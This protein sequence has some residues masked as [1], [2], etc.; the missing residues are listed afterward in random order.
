[1]I[2]DTLACT[3][4]R[5]LLVNYRIEPDAVAPLLPAGFRPQLVGGFAVGGVCFIRLAGI[6][7]SRFPQVLGITTEN[8]AHR[9][10]VEWGDER[11]ARVGVYVPRRDTDSHIASVAGGRVFPGRYH[12]AR[13]DVDES[14]DA[15]AIDVRSR[16]GVVNLSVAGTES[17]GLDS[18]LFASLDDATTF[19]RRGALGFSPAADVGCLDAVRL[20]SVSWDAR[21]VQLR[22]MQS[23]LFD[24][25]SIFPRGSCV[26]DSALVMRNLPVR[27]VTEDP[28][29]TAHAPLVA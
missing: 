5:R 12:L 3:I 18:E 27:W 16:D 25:L 19:F 14:G 6:R 20:D 23:S 29:A 4:E 7:P 11:D 21:P 13:F 28:V 8:V 10:A 17:D 1:M 15:L 26:L 24:D 2:T 22:D 9:F